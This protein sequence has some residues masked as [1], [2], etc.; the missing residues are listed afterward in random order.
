MAEDKGEE[1]DDDSDM[2][3]SVNR[4]YQNLIVAAMWLGYETGV[5]GGQR[6]VAA[7]W[8][9]P[10]AIAADDELVVNLYRRIYQDVIH[11][12]NALLQ[13]PARHVENRNNMLMPDA[14]YVDLRQAGLYVVASF[15]QTLRAQGLHMLAVQAVPHL[16]RFR[17]GALSPRSW[18]GE[19]LLPLQGPISLQE[20]R[21]QAGHL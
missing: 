16:Q 17:Y 2:E 8:K 14:F 19:Q 4:I 1:E 7:L 18:D 20:R 12:Q 3:G 21:L 11:D 6:T 5:R 9:E 10:E 15:A 13:P